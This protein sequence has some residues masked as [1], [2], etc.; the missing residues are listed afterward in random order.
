MLEVEDSEKTFNTAYT[1]YSERC[2][3]CGYLKPTTS[4]IVEL[5]DERMK[6]IKRIKLASITY[7]IAEDE[8][9]FYGLHWDL[10]QY[11]YF[12]LLGATDLSIK[13]LP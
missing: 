7:F 13:T 4:T 8:I 6:R 10:Q 1:V 11:R 3:R 2:T 9:S 5:W 12:R